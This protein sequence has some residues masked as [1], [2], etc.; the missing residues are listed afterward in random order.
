MGR[1]LRAAG[2]YLGGNRNEAEDSLD[3]VCGISE[4]AL[5]GEALLAP[6]LGGRPAPED[7]ILWEKAL[8]LHLQQRAG[9]QVWGWKNPRSMFLLP[10][11][12]ALIPDIRMIHVVRDGREIATSANTR[13]YSLHVPGGSGSLAEKAAFWARSN[14]AVARFAAARLGDRYIRVRYEDLVV[15]PGGMA[16][17]IFGRLGLP[18]LIGRLPPEASGA[19]RPRRFPDLGQADR[20][21]VEHAARPGLEAFGYV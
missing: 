16:D 18:D 10:Y 1:I 19:P 3:L 14:L 21:A 6:E 9:E 15:D 2:V 13:Q 8:N 20:E 4:L 11:S 5:K 7:L 17:E 12:L